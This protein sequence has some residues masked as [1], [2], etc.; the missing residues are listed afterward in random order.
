MATL[1]LPA[2]PSLFSSSCALLEVRE[3]DEVMADSQPDCRE[4]KLN[5]ERPHDRTSS[6]S[7]EDEEVSE[8]I[9][10]LSVDCCDDDDDDDATATTETAL[11]APQH[12]ESRTI[13]HHET[14][15]PIQD[16]D[17]KSTVSFPVI[18]GGLRNL[19]NTCYMASAIQM[20]A[21]L[22]PLMDELLEL[23][24]PRVVVE[25]HDKVNGE[26]SSSLLDTFLDVIVRL[27]KGE[28]LEPAVFK[29]VL[30]KRTALFCGYQQQDA[31]EFITTLLDVLDED[32]KKQSQKERQQKVQAVVLSHGE[33]LIRCND[34]GRSA[35]QSQE[36]LGSI[37]EHAG[38]DT[39]M[40]IEMNTEKNNASTAEEDTHHADSIDIGEKYHCSFE[41]EAAA[42]LDSSLIE[43]DANGTSTAF[44]ATTNQEESSPQI[45][46]GDVDSSPIW[47]EEDSSKK[48]LKP[49]LS[50]IEHLNGDSPVID[51]EE[52]SHLSMNVQPL[53]SQRPI[54]RN[55]SDLNLDEI[56]QL[57]H[58]MPSPSREG[59]DLNPS[60]TQVAVEPRCKLVGG[61]MNLNSDLRYE[62]VLPSSSLENND[63][64]R[65]DRAMSNGPLSEGDQRE[66]PTSDTTDTTNATSDP[67]NAETTS[68]IESYLTTEVRIRL[69]CD[70]CKY[71]RTHKETF[72]HLSLE[73][74]SGSY[75]SSTGI[76]SVQDGLAHFFAPEQRQ[77]KCEKCFC[78]T[79][80]QTMQI[81]KLPRALLLHFKRFI[82]E[83]SDDYSSISYRKNTSPVS[84]GTRMVVRENN[85]QQRGLSEYD[86][87]QE[88]DTSVLSDY[89]SADCS[90]PRPSACSRSS[91]TKNGDV[92]QQTQYKLKSIVNH[93]GQS[94]SCGHY[95][96]DAHRRIG[97]S[98]DWLRFN[99]SY[100][101]QI[102]EQQA[103]E[104][105][106][107]TAY[108]ILYETE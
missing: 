91:S 88:N 94:A 84:F 90:L 41:D 80:T 99:D 101:S 87:T 58:T 13:D 42:M 98:C 11:P 27:R 38:E 52:L 24:V 45:C 34:D 93:I 44:V 72:W 43:R 57:L 77:L 53:Q 47:I 20:L 108:M 14:E 102:T 66:V 19:G 105:S 97:N 64:T 82:V 39:E 103:T 107:S 49:D 7:S 22:D 21:S 51:Q 104:G 74:G 96:A 29:Q 86:S 18:P 85:D 31:H 33:C 30:D 5:A 95:T 3:G 73:L 70:S 4:E 65:T 23:H 55:F 46:E 28:T 81:T 50:E 67:V 32:H 35:E 59:L 1:T 37:S 63:T 56:G 8:W 78:E 69:T 36:K 68:P 17:E 79:A 83:V 106:A 76:N 60:A 89:L 12:V 48:R 25:D 71:T 40:N 61:R 15:Q 6:Q 16:D 9:P 2:S 54:A 100:V 26:E 10:T 75:H 92:I 62:S